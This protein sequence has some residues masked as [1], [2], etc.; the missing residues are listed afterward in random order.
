MSRTLYSVRNST[1]LRHAI[2]LCPPEILMIPRPRTLNVPNLMFAI[3]VP[4]NG[5]CMIRTTIIMNK[6]LVFISLTQHRSQDRITSTRS[7]RFTG[8]TFVSG[9][10]RDLIVPKIPRVG[11][12]DNG[13]VVLF[14]R[15]R[16]FPFLVGNV[17]GKFLHRSVLVTP[18]DFL[19]LFFSK[20][21][22][23]GGAGD[24]C[25]LIVGSFLFVKCS[26]K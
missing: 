10:L 2:T 6:A 18:S 26:S 4:T 17:N 15:I 22:R 8:L 5:I 7:D 3:N 19:C 12:S 11:I 1:I 24:F 25:A 9:L 20:V 13:T 14:G 23:Y 21:Y 16:G